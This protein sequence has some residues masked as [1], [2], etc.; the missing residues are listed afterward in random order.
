MRKLL[1]TFM[2]CMTVL[3]IAATGVGCGGARSKVDSAADLETPKPPTNPWS[4]VPETSTTVGRIGVEELRKTQLFPLWRELEGEQKLASWVAVDKIAR[5]TFGG[6]GQTREDMSYVAALEGEFFDNE[7]AQLAKRDNVTAEERGLLLLY[8]RPEGYWSQIAPGLIIMCTPDRVDD[9]VARAGH[10]DGTAVKEGALW[11]SLATRVSMETAHVGILAE[12]PDGTGR[13]M[14]DKQAS[15]YGLGSFARDATRLG[16]GIEVGTEYR[17]V[18]VAETPDEQ[19]ANA[20]SEEVK[21]TIDTVANNF[22]VRMLGIGALISKVRVSN[23]NNYVFVRG[24]VAEAD[25]NNVIERVHS[26]L[27]LA[28]GAGSLGELK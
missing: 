14:L 24:T 25:F 22:F 23:A 2:T 6:T 5:V 19:K 26:A 21:K 13:A 7:L 11:K 10:G 16:L 20:T 4:W 28:N 15:R 1:M 17:F 27:S 12:D 18:A 3:G 8:R 9:M